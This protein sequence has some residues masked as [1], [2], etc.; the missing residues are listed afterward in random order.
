VRTETGKK[1]NPIQNFGQK[2]T[3]TLKKN[4]PKFRQRPTKSLKN[5]KILEKK[6]RTPKIFKRKVRSMKKKLP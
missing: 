1:I 4:N 5:F 6:D 3:A 2:S